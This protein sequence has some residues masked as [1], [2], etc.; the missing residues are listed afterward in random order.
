MKQFLEKLKASF[1]ARSLRIGGYSVAVT[2]IVLVI[3][4]AVNVIAGAMPATMTRIDTT[5]NQLYS[6]SQQTE[7]VI[8]GLQTDV[9]VYWV[10]R[11]GMEDDVIG[12]MLDKYD[13][14]SE[15]LHVVKKDPDLYPTFLK[16]FNLTT[17]TDNS[18]IAESSMRFSYADYNQM[19]ATQEEPDYATGGYVEKTYFIG[20]SMITSIIDYAAK[21]QIPKLYALTG[22]GEASLSAFFADAVSKENIEMA[23]L[24]LLTVDAVPEDA[25]CVLINAPTSDLTEEELTKLR[26]YI[27]GGGNLMLITD[28]PEKA[29]LA[30]L[31]ALMADYG[32]TATKGVVIEAD[33][34]HYAYSYPHYLLPTLNEHTVTK[35]M[36]TGTYYVLLP[37]AQGLVIDSELPEGVTVTPLLTTSKSAFSK[38]AGYK[39]STYEKEEGDIDGPFAL[40]VAITDSSSKSNMVWVTSSR[41]LNDDANTMVAGG[42]QDLFL[43][44]LN[45]MCNVGD[46]G[47]SIHA[48]D[49][50][51]EYLTINAETA[52]ILT[53][54][55][56]GVIPLIYMTIGLVVRIRRRNR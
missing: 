11:S 37:V 7:K 3:V 10:V 52:N 4:I 41:F 19:V 13:A 50:S 20:E 53:V 1:S 48:K 28:P 25:N 6:I 18:V 44:S 12:E 23:Q 47:I 35:P 9:T 45:W 56:V 46:S 36:M 43:N 38:V 49:L 26:A 2:A 55:V 16:Q 15:R 51:Y 34:G 33:G 27:K 31:A 29:P 32:V 40:G 21:I 42:N 17:L 14:L 30:N 24:H 39:L 22:H 5:S 8:R 54:L